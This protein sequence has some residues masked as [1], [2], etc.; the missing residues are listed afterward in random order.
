M[1]PSSNA[2]SEDE[3]FPSSPDI[4]QSLP[5]SA[6]ISEHSD[7]FSPPLNLS[8]DPDSDSDSLPLP[9]PKRRRLMTGRGTRI[10][11][12]YEEDTDGL[13]IDEPITSSYRPASSELYSSSEGDM[14]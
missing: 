10:P 9:P 7:S 3:F 14:S 1:I 6:T 13:G 2:S 11:R 4:L 5:E 8:D 12:T